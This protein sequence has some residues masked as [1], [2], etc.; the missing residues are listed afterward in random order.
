MIV[1]TLI[2]LR[3]SP[4]PL[5]LTGIIRVTPTRGLRPLR[6][7]VQGRSHDLKN[8]RRLGEVYEWR[9][10]PNTRCGFREER[11]VQR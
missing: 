6:F 2:P 8:G 3:A 7:I 11:D 4:L 5:H 1:E 10:T 9:S